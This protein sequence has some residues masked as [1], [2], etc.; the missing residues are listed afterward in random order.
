M[1]KLRE[2]RQSAAMENIQV[3]VNLLVED[4]DTH[5]SLRSCGESLLINNDFTNPSVSGDLAIE[6][7]ITLLSMIVF[8][9]PRRVI[10]HIICLLL[11]L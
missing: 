4:N 9:L 5:C 11:I 7:P 10:P 2:D 6:S 8:H 1:D 3:T